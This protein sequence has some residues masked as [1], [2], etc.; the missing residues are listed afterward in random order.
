M[1]N[2][3]FY[4]DGYRAYL[5]GE[6]FSPPDSY[7]GTDVFASE[8]KAGYQQAEIDLSMTNQPAITETP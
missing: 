8:Y 1:T 2:S 6:P 5:N 3:T 4:H 7:R